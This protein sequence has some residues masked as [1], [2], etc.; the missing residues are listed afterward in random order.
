M[1][2]ARN[3]TLTQVYVLARE[4]DRRYSAAVE[5]LRSTFPQQ[6]L[7]VFYFRDGQMMSPLA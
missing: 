6:G 7:P 3:P 2:A 5:K 4:G 1:A